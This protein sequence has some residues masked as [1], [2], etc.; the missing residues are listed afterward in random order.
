MNEDAAREVCLLRAIETNPT[1]DALL[2]DA[3][4]RYAA[5]TAAEL[6]RWDR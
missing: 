6:A 1:A 3:D 4:R 2:S 5:R